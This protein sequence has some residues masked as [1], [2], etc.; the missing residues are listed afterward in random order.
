MGHPDLK[1]PAAVVR[2]CH[3]P[4]KKEVSMG[5]LRAKRE[6]DLLIRGLSPLTQKIYIRAVG[7][8]TTY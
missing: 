5:A 4:N 1:L 6:Q 8:L 2:N 7:G 3:G